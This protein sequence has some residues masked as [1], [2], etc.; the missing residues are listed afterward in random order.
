MG[1]ALGIIMPL[2]KAAEGALL[3]PVV[4]LIVLAGLVMSARLYLQ[5]HTLREV[6]YGAALGFLVG[7]FGMIILF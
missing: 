1:G 3:Y 4:L 2:N 7:F 6:G 5:V